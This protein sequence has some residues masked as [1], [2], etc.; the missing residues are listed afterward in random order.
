MGGVISVHRAGGGKGE[1]DENSDWDAEEEEEE[2]EEEEA[3][4]AERCC[5][6]RRTSSSALCVE[7]GAYVCFHNNTSIFLL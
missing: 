6:L 2:E 7:E 3:E 5:L 1:A 4:E